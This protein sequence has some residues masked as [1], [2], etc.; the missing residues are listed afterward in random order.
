M[1]GNPGLTTCII[2]VRGTIP[3]CAGEPNQYLNEDD[4]VQDYPRV[5]GGTNNVYIN[6]DYSYGLSPRVRGNPLEINTL[7]IIG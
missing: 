7:T 1:R 3:A 6:T 5:C 4:F 2:K